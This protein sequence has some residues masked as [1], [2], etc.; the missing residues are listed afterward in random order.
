MKQALI[1]ML[2]SKKAIAALLATAAAIAGKLGYN[3]DT[4]SI[5]TITGPLMAYIV[6][7]GIADHGAQGLK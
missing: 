6:S 1:D 7:Q 3:L 5:L 2:S 4:E